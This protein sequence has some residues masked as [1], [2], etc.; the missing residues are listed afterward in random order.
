M[1]FNSNID[2]LLVDGST[3]ESRLIKEALFRSQI[4]YNIFHVDDGEKALGYLNKQ[5]TYKNCK[6]PSLILLNL[7]LPRIDGVELLRI[8]KEDEKLK[9]I[10]VVMLIDSSYEKYINDSYGNGAN[11]VIVKPFDFEEFEELLRSLE[12]FWINQTLLPRIKD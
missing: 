6:S 2:L 5:S 11:A 12:D 10:P 4:G 7:N 3:A 9:I 8:I 1:F